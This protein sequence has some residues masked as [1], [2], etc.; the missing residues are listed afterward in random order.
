VDDAAKVEERPRRWLRYRLRSAFLL[1]TLVAIAAA[2]VG[3]HVRRCHR[4]E[5]AIEQLLSS[6]NGITLDILYASPFDRTIGLQSPEQHRFGR[7]E[8]WTVNTFRCG[9]AWLTRLL[10]VDIFKTVTFLQCAG[11]PGRPNTVR[12]GGDRGQ[13]IR[14]IQREFASGIHDEDMPLIGH[15]VHLRQLTLTTSAVTNKGLAELK[16]LKRLQMLY[17]KNTAVTDNGLAVL[18]ELP[19]LQELDLDSTDVTDKCVLALS[20]CNKL[21]KLTLTRTLVSESAIE[22]LQLQLP[23]CE[24]IR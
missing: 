6:K 17:L 18:A 21:K 1:V 2:W 7:S 5:Q 4:E 9:P 22:S 10:G 3:T 24:I 13:P 23:S 11:A 16:P 8:S 20:A 15:L 14:V 12:Y 19:D